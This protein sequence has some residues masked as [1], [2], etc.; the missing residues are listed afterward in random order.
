M[1]SDMNSFGYSFSTEFENIVIFGHSLNEADYSYFFPMFDKLN[2]LNLTS[3]GV[4]VFAYYV[5]DKEQE[6]SIKSKRRN[7]ISNMIYKYA[8]EK[9]IANPKRTMDSLSIQ[10]KI[11]AYEIPEFTDKLKYS[12][13]RLDADWHNIYEEIEIY[14]KELAERG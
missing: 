12:K 5:W 8:I 14:E 10:K 11:V 1:E 13:C 9:G 7:D 6:D 4:V 3:N 2:L